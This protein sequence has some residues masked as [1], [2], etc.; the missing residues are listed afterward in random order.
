MKGV[1]IWRD[2][3]YIEITRTA[4]KR[5]LQRSHGFWFLKIWS[6]ALGNRHPAPAYYAHTYVYVH[7]KAIKY[8]FVSGREL[9]SVT[10]FFLLAMVFFGPGSSVA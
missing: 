1:I 10:R 2:L 4:C 3:F 8:N 9:F 5:R 7:I 6:G